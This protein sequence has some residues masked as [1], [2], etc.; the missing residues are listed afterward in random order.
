[1]KI[2]FLNCWEGKLL[3]PLKKF[4]EAHKADTDIFCFQEA[5]TSVQ[6]A[7]DDILKLHTKETA[8]KKWQ[9][10]SED[11]HDVTLATYVR[12]GIEIVDAR[13]L[14]GDSVDLG[15]GLYT[16]LAVGTKP[17]HLINMHGYPWPGKLDTSQRIEQS[18]TI[19][20]SLRG[21]SGV[22]IAGGDLNVLPETKSVTMFSDSNFQDLI[23]DYDI[24]TTRNHLSWDLHPTKLYYSDYVFVHDGTT[25]TNFSVP[26]IE[27]S[28]HLPMVLEI[29]L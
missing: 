3:D 26:D 2:I 15:I 11:L 6:S 23:R 17:V 27:I 29:L 20:E 25:V 7:L 13:L 1:V 18:R 8:Q 28:D 10:D 9:H 21:L 5:G 19:L 4:I 24:K 14:L 22:R 12:Q 16:H